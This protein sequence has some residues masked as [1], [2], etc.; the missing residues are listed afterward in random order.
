M[1]LLQLHYAK[2][3]L[4]YRAGCHIVWHMPLRLINVTWT[5]IHASRKLKLIYN[6]EDK[7]A[8]LKAVHL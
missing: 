7:D 6:V 4:T 1:K 2:N 3:G 5:N 8:S